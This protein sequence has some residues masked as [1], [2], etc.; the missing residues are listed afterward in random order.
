M[1][2]AIAKYVGGKVLTAALTVTAALVVIWYWRLDPDARA[3]IWT[4]ARLVLT[5]I[6]LAA[7]LPWALFFVPPL[8]LRAESNLISGLML[9]G[10]LLLDVLA[11]LWL[12]GWGADSSLAWAVMILGFLCAAVYNFL[13]CEYIATRA[14]AAA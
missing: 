9:L 14:D 12:A 8:V 1:I 10:Y 13:V 5:W 11:A 3:A 4:T 2:R 6:G 7:V